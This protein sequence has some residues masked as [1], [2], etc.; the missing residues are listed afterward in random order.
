MYGQETVQLPLGEERFVLHVYDQNLGSGQDNLTVRVVDTTPPVL[1]V[2]PATLC[3]WPPMHQRVKFS[4][5]ADIEAVATDVCDVDPVVR[6]VSVTSNE[7]DNGLGDGDTAGDVAFSD[8][9]FCVRKER[10]GTGSGRRYTVTIEAR[11][12]SGNAST[13]DVLVNVP[14]DSSRSSLSSRFCHDNGRPIA[15]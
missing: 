5:D 6:I 12:D 8:R 15:E 4:L 7:P 9:A 10:S 2:N 14:H 11:D 3:L 13:Q 1:T